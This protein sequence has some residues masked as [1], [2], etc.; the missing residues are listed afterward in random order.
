MPLV[1][2]RRRCGRGRP[3]TVAGS[4]EL[5]ATTIS[6]VVAAVRD[7]GPDDPVPRAVRRLGSFNRLPR[8]ARDTVRRLVDGDEEFRAWLVETL[9]EDAVGRPG[10]VWLTRPEGWERT[11]DEAAAALTDRPVAETSADARWR[12][13]V[14]GARRAAAR[15]EERASAAEERAAEATR[16]LE[17]LG[18]ELDRW[19]ERA[20]EAE[21][22]RDEA[23]AERSRAV[24]SLKELENRHAEV[25]AERRRLSERLAALDGRAVEAP[26]LP[27][28]VDERRLRIEVRRL[29]RGLRELQKVVA[30]LE[31][32]VAVDGPRRR[33]LLPPGIVADTDEAARALAAVPGVV[34]VVDGY[35]V[36]R[37]VWDDRTLVDQRD[38][39]HRRLAVLAASTGA[40]FEI[41]WDGLEAS[42]VADVGDGVREIFTPADVEADDEILRR[43]AVRVD[44]SLVV[45]S[46]DRRVRDGAQAL[47]VDV[48]A[49]E[50]LLALLGV[51][52]PP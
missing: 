10:W 38:E 21:R 43:A 51:T 46:S 47:G 30:G 5:L 31:R 39:L 20:L 14:D 44:A 4:D 7:A 9:D 42:A 28:G 29:R 25:V 52:P 1:R 8:P 50:R 16:E 13:K 26:E 11:L 35:N 27:E 45:V 34:F 37:R 24:R 6:L 2:H 40:V 22:G 36:S 3:L 17:E 49:S 23:L 19:R 18:E 41:V 48:L 12:R 33:S 15:A 32:L